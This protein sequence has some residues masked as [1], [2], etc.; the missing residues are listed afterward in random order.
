ME[1]IIRPVSAENLDDYL[2]FFDRDGFSDNPDWAGCYCAFNHI[3]DEEGWQARTGLQN[4]EYVSDKIREGKLNGYLAYS[5]GHVVGWVN[6]DDRLAYK[7]LCGEPGYLEAGLV[8][9]P[10]A[11]LED[12]G[13]VS[14]E[15]GPAGITD[16]TG[17]T[18]LTGKAIVCYLIRPDMRGKGV[19]SALLERVVADAAAQGYDFVEA[20]PIN[21]ASS[22]AGEYHGPAVMYE[23]AGFQKVLS[24]PE[25]NVWR[26]RLKDMSD[27]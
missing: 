21:G 22:C 13:S 20:F 12:A 11:V 2:Q 3:T 9:D 16:L 19:A 18:A 15:A 10:G 17:K 24:F 14:R 7:R 23:K 8:F 1:L 27:R 4:R 5:E 26:I 6:A 25:I